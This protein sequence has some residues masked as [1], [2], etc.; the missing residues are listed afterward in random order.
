M[1]RYPSTDAQ[2]AAVIKRRTWRRHSGPVRVQERGGVLEYL[3]YRILPETLLLL[4]SH[5]FSYG[6]D[7]FTAMAVNRAVSSHLYR[8]EL[9][10]PGGSRH[11]D[12]ASGPYDLAGINE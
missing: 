10:R 2:Q 8:V 9:T 3:M 5:P 4:S 7:E 6:R 12:T 1:I 11:G